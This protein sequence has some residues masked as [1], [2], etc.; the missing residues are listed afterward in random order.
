MQEDGTVTLPPVGAVSVNG[1]TVPQAA[2][3]IRK[4]YTDKQLLKP[5]N[6]NRILVNLLDPRQEQIL[7]L[8][9]ESPN[10]IVGPEG[11]ISGAKRGT[12]HEIDLPAYE[13]DVLHAL[14]RTG[15]LPGLDAFNEVVIYR[16]CFAD[17]AA[18]TALRQEFETRPQPCDLAASGRCVQ[19]IRIPLRTL[20]GVAPP[21]RPE[22]VILHTGDV[23][24]LECRD[25]QVFYTAGLLP[26][27]VH[28]LPRDYDLDVIAAISQSRGPLVNGGFAVSNLSGALIAPGVGGPSP[29]LLTVLRRTPGGGQVPITVNLNRALRGIRELAIVVQSGRADDADPPG[30][31]GARALTRY[32]A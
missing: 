3:A 30:T 8:R 31:A 25:T 15:G 26:P 29:S 11:V 21:F 28:V 6:R 19:T 20:P 32:T 9:E 22:D 1:M 13:N 24:L 5:G 4:V 16:N 2:A 17:D 27:A 12:G 7:V 14:T 23:V 10:L 18:R